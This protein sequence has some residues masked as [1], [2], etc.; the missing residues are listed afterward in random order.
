MALK[1]AEW[2]ATEAESDA[3]VGTAKFIDSKSAMNFLLACD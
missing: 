2:I 3:Y 1:R